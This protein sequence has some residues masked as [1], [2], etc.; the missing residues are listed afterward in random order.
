MYQ[1]VA[2][3]EYRL[4][5]LFTYADFYLCSIRL[6][7]YAVESKRNG[8]ILILLE[9]AV[10]VGVKKSEVFRLVERVLLDIEP[11]R[12]YMG[13]DDVHAVAD[14]VIADIEQHNHLVHVDRV[15]LVSF[16]ELFTLCDNI[17]KVFVA[18][19]FCHG[20]DKPGALALRLAAVKKG[21]IISAQFLEFLQVFSAVG[22]P[23]V[24]ADHKCPPYL[25]LLRTLHACVF[26]HKTAFF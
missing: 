1:E 14:D 19:L 3:D 18:A 12:V 20:H 7:H 8:H 24:F 16:C 5:V 6:H 9:A 25:I 10:I 26:Y 22:I 2:D 15:D 21:N 4:I 13:S 11:R 23:C 17:G